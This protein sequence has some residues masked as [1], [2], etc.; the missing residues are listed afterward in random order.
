MYDCIWR[1]DWLHKG[2]T[3]LEVTSQTVESL[4]PIR[5]IGLQSVYI[6]IF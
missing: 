1:L 5:E 2:F 6:G 3:D 4:R